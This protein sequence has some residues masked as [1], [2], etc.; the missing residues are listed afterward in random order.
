MV[1]GAV[2]GGIQ[3][4][5]WSLKLGY[6]LAMIAL[7][8]IFLGLGVSAIGVALNFSVL[9]DILYLVQMWLPF[10]LSPVIAWLFTSVTAYLAWRVA[11]IGFDVLHGVLD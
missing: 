5:K 9:F 6:A 4:V 2:V 1:E 3:A 11:I 8:V 7:F 10:N